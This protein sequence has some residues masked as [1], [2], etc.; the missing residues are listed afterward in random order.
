M[1]VA[2]AKQD[3]TETR[4][5]G[6]EMPAGAGWATEARQGALSRLRG[7]GLPTRRDEYWKYTDP[8]SLTQA[9][10]PRAALFDP[11]E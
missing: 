11:R 5:A 2:Q 8:A 6:L 1:A 9:A 3:L 10:A 7:M 4:I